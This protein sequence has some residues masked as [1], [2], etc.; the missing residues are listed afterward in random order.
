M[1]LG[2][3]DSPEALVRG[4]MTAPFLVDPYPAYDKLRT[5]A[6]V[7][8][9]DLGL[10]FVSRYS[11]CETLF[12]SPVFG[13]G[14]RLR[15]DP[16]YEDSSSLQLLG[17]M[18]PFVDPP[19]HTR[20]RRS[21]GS[22]FAPRAVQ[23]LRGFTTQLVN[24]LLDRMARAGGGDLLGDFARRIPVAVM[25]EMLGGV[26]ADD[27]DRCCAWSDALIE[28]VHPVT[29]DAMLERADAAAEG[30]FTYF[31]EIMDERRAHPTDDMMGTLVK[32][33]DRT[34]ALSDDEFRAMA[35]SL[36]GAAY[37]NTANHIATGIWTLLRH[38]V[39]LALLREQPERAKV[40]VDELLR[41]EPPVQIT[42]PRVASEDVE[43]GGVTIPA[44]EQVCGVLGAAHRDPLRYRNPNQLDIARDDGGSLAFAFGIHSCIGAAVARL[45]A[46]IAITGFVDRFTQA[47]VIDNEPALYTA[48]LP[49]LRS[50]E[51][52][53][54][55]VT[56]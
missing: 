43:L 12:R 50:F 48:G 54:V 49:S 34:G 15:D 17:H 16:R 47:T 21:V 10:W 41:F 33:H 35:T 7:Y 37:H 11:T 46:E 42:L 38:P 53:R 51:S 9:S 4:F 14:F 6:P 29:D 52:L 19:D 31:G 3:A 30:F 23:H 36:V 26:A 18:M 13:Q 2:S 8:R 27:Q 22:F 40:A 32:E 25:C 5:I 24:Q 20:I 39:Q 55:T 45:E 56:P 1:T 28:A 44:G